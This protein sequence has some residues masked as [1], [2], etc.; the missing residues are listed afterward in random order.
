MQQE[1]DVMERRAS[2]EKE[3]A[4]LTTRGEERAQQEYHLR[5]AVLDEE[6]KNAPDQETRDR[7]AAEKAE[8]LRQRGAGIASGHAGSGVRSTRGAAMQRVG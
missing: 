6:E 5:K 7:I 8:L 4:R 1:Y 2:V 3:I